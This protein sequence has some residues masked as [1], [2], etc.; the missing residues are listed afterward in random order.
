MVRVFGR[1]DTLHYWEL[2]EAQQAYQWEFA[3]ALAE[4]EG[5]PF[6]VIVCPAHAL[7]ALPHGA[8]KQ[9]VTGGTYA[10]LVNLLGYPAG[11]V[12]VTRVRLSE[13]SDR[14]G[15][16]DVVL[17]AARRAERGTA[18][19]PVG[20]QVIARPWREHVA[21]AALAAIEAGVRASGEHPGMPEL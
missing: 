6:D 18:G 2:V 7:P 17:R 14:Q 8:S 9:I 3:R 10:I 1:H 20:V 5:G 4:D 13:E 11:I 15:S 12:P 21:L 19:L 16:V